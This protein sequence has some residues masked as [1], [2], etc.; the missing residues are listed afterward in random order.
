MSMMC[1]TRVHGLFDQ[2][3]VIR[4]ARTVIVIRNLLIRALLSLD[5]QGLIQQRDLK[6]MWPG[7]EAPPTQLRPSPHTITGSPP[8]D[9]S[10]SMRM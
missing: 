6:L 5:E 2:L 8:Q 9:G 10:S 7:A 4:H 3:G 1:L